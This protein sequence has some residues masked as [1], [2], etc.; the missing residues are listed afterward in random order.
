MNRP[1]LIPK[2]VA[3]IAVVFV[4]CLGCGSDSTGPNGNGSDDPALQFGAVLTESLDMFF[5]NNALAFLTLQ[6]YAPAMQAALSGAP[7]GG[8]P[9]VAALG[10]GPCIDAGLLG[11]TYAYS[12]QQSAYSPTTTSGAPQ[13]GVRFLLYQGQQENGYVD[14]VCPS[15]LPAISISLTMVWDDVTVLDMAGVG[16]FNQN[17]TWNFNSTNADIRDPDSNAVM[18]L[19]TGGT[20]LATQVITSRV[21]GDIPGEGI[22]FFFSRD[23]Q[24][25]VDASANVIATAWTAFLD[26]TG[27]SANSMTGFATLS[28]PASDPEVIACLSGTYDN[29]N[30]T[31]ASESCATTFPVATGISAAQRSAI[32]DGYQALVAMLEAMT[33]LIRA[34]IDIAIG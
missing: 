23:D 29:L 5:T 12:F 26:Y 13:D 7:G 17:L 27:A 21:S 33:S 4:L 32:E 19:S 15:T 20:G 10:A 31:A 24:A 3:A 16:Q 25:G 2:G 1:H 18:G 11:T 14:I 6:N 8:Q 28:T 22:T 30:A 9:E 34:G